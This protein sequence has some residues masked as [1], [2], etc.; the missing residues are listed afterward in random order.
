MKY[1]SLIMALSLLL[2]VAPSFAQQPPPT[3]PANSCDLAEYFTFLDTSLVDAVDNANLFLSGNDN[4]IDG[5]LDIYQDLSAVRQELENAAP[6]F[7]KCGETPVLINIMAIQ[8]ITSWQDILMTYFY[9]YH[10]PDAREE[11]LE[12]IPIQAGRAADS[13]ERLDELRQEI[14]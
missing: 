1:V 3:L 14:E 6:L 12:I 5:I 7:Y 8:T 2:I 13:Q 9:A 10:T 4:D 11:L